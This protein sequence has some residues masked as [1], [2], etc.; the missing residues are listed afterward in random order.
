MHLIIHFQFSIF[1]LHFVVFHRAMFRWHSSFLEGVCHSTRTGCLVQ[2]TALHAVIKIS[3]LSSSRTHSGKPWDARNVISVDE[4]LA[5][6][7]NVR[8]V[9]GLWADVALITAEIQTRQTFA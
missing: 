5:I 4:Y 9:T 2:T 8:D 7:Y 6:G 3:D 1:Q